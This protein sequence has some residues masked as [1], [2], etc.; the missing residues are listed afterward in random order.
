MHEDAVTG[1]CEFLLFKDFLHLKMNVYMLYYMTI[2]FGGVIYDNVTQCSNR[3]SVVSVKQ[4]DPESENITS[5]N[6]S[7]PFKILS[8]N[9][10][11]FFFSK[12][13][14]SSPFREFVY[15]LYVSV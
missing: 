2:S 10:L 5:P 13:P 6:S 8:R 9:S 7:L 14:R 1:R 11:S 3:I 12:T 4:N 15:K